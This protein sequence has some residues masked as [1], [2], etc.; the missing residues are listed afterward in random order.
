MLA[1]CIGRSCFQQMSDSPGDGHTVAFDAA[2]APGFGS[3]DGSDVFTLA[4]FLAKIQTH[5]DSDEILL[6]KGERCL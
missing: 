1:V 4:G 5:K 2:V 6:L 3:Q